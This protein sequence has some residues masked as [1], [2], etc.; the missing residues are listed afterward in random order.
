MATSSSDILR[1]EITVTLPELIPSLRSSCY[2]RLERGI[3][4]AST[5][6][7]CAGE[8][9][10][11]G[12]RLTDLAGQ[13]GTPLF[14]LDTQEIQD[15]MRAYRAALPDVEIAYAGKALLTK[16]VARLAADEGL[17]LDVCSG[18]EIAVAAAAGFPAERMVFH[19]NAKTP[20]EIKLALAIGV[21]R[22][23]VDSYDDIDQLGAMASRPQRV[24]VRVTPN[25]DAGTHRA[26]ATGIEDQKFGMPVSAASAIRRVLAHPALRLVGLHCHIGSQIRDVGSYVTAATRMV[27]VLGMLRR[28]CGIELDELD[29]G[30][31]HAVAY[32]EGESGFD[33]AAFAR[34]VP[35][36]VRAA[37]AAQQVPMPRLVVEPGRALVARAGVTVYRV[38]TVKRLTGGRT[39]V[40]VDGGMSDNPR[41]ALYGARYVMRLAGRPCAAPLE[42]MTVVG[43]HCEAGDVLAVDA[44]LPSDVH[45]GDLIAV[46]CTGAYHHS[47]AS[48]YNL[49]GRPPVIGVAGGVITP[50][51]RRETTEDVLSRDLC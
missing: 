22:I 31:G 43:R 21:G 37:C 29:L 14:V 44:P 35:A 17:S 8:L 32:A 51:V 9:A 33:L 47:M 38:V 11:G 48:T 13:F 25:V 7:N 12:V 46:P 40:A 26:L 19:G 49:V 18:G 2:A 23:V 10:V 36:T 50:L 39:F 16:A 45:P 5:T 27:E 24:L 30:G 34:Q 41:P 3:W 20:E 28:E 6:S 4:P 15:R 1:I 42:P